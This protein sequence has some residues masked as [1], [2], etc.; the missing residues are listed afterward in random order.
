MA[1]GRGS[2]TAFSA[3]TGASP[4]PY[5]PHYRTLI[6]EYTRH[7]AVSGLPDLIASRIEPLPFS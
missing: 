5:I 7:K 1:G 6:G 2:G 4:T 3:S